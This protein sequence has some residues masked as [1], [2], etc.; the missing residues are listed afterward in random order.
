M[1]E[2]RGKY[3]RKTIKFA[4]AAA[5]LFVLLI[6]SVAIAE[7]A[8]W[9][10]LARP[11][12]KQLSRVMN[13][14][15]TLSAGDFKIRF[16]GK[17]RLEIGSL[18]IAAPSWS[19]TAV[20][21]QAQSMKLTLGYSDIWAAYKGQ[22]LNVIA[23]SAGQLNSHLER[24]AD[25]RV[26]WQLRQTQTLPPPIPHFNRLEIS[27]GTVIYSDEQLRLAI[28]T[29]L[30]AN[31]ADNTL[32]VQ[33][34]GQY[35]DMPLKF[36]VISSNTLPWESRQNGNPRVGLTADATIGRAAL[37]F[38][39]TAGDVSSFNDVRGQFTLKGPSLSAVGDPVGVT[40]PT[41]SAFNVNGVV[42]KEA[43][44]WNVTL[45]SL[46]I[47]SSKLSG[48][49]QFDK[50]NNRNL[51]SGRLDGTHLKLADLG[52]VIGGTAI[53]NQKTDNK[54]SS[55]KTKVLPSR[56]F[57]LAALRVMDANVLIDIK[58]VDLN[59][60][61]LEPLRP[62]KAHL[63]LLAGVLTISQI[64]ANTAQGNVTGQI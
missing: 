42:V 7:L 8:G 1:V 22:R 49:F 45:K 3:G 20:M 26:S 59:T 47:G 43:D 21:V 12:E 2:R 34:T 31:A 46:R 32:N 16:L 40:L 10:F 58:E 60:P 35:R 52:P 29:K 19:K 44:Q 11:L 25:G 23:L 64:Q 5:A 28:N 38:E 50:K 6:L 36:K 39:G 41:T 30:S 37:S 4:I 53:E 61:L 14:E 24:T 55:K 18:V 9:P 62:L 48:A 17:I 51:L 15:L 33:G 27:D 13:R 57:D 63:Q 54:S 56:P